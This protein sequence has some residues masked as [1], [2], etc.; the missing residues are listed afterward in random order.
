MLDITAHSFQQKRPCFRQPPAGRPPTASP[1]QRVAVGSEEPPGLALFENFRY[2]QT[3]GLSSAGQRDSS[4]KSVRIPAKKSLAS[5]PK[6]LAAG[7]IANFQTRLR[8]FAAPAEPRAERAVLSWRGRVR[9][10]HTRTGAPSP[11]VL[12]TGEPTSGPSAP[13]FPSILSG[14][15]GLSREPAGVPLP[16]GDAGAVPQ[17][18][19][20]QGVPPGEAQGVPGLGQAEGGCPEGVP[21][22]ALRRGRRLP[23]DV[24]AGGELRQLPPLPQAAEGPAGLLDPPGEAG[25][26]PL[27][28]RGGQAVLPVECRQ[29]LL[30][31][32]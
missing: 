29:L 25:L 32:V 4:L 3:T 11:S 28:G 14:L 26:H 8:G 15:A 20:A 22:G 17:L 16:A 2:A 5:G 9:I 31:P 10:E 12:K 27:P 18:Q 13:M 6:S 21:Q 7:H 30:R 23:V 1:A 24:A 19:Q